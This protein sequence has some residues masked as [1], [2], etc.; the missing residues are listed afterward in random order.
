MLK[1]RL[2]PDFLIYYQ[3]SLVYA[4]FVLMRTGSDLTSHN[5]VFVLMDGVMNML[6]GSYLTPGLEL[7]GDNGAG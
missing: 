5:R 6:Y 7:S 1:Y 3:G 2:N 4:K